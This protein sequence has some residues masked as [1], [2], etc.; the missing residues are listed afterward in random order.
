MTSIFQTSH[1]MVIHLVDDQ[2]KALKEILSAEV[3]ADDSIIFS[4]PFTVK[5][6]NPFMI[7]PLTTPFTSVPNFIKLDVLIAPDKLP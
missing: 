6:T 5:L 3:K 2:V 4:L 1:K 7:S